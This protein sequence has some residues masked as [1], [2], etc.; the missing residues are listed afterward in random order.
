[1]PECKRNN[2]LLHFEEK[3]AKLF[4]EAMDKD[5]RQETLLKIRRTADFPALAGTVQ[6]INQFKASEESTVSE[7]TNIILKDYALTTKLLKVVNSVH[8]QQSGQVTTISRAV[9][10]LGIENIRNLALA[11]RLIDF[12]KNKDSGGELMDTL[13]RAFCAG[14]IA[15]K[16]AADLR[17]A[18]EEEAFICAMLHPLGKILVAYSMP[19]KATEIAK[20][21]RQHEISEDQ[22]SAMVLGISYEAI[23]TTM[24]T[25]WNLPQE[26]IRSMHSSP[27]DGF[28]GRATESEKLNML[29]T[30]GSGISDILASDADI[31]EM[32]VK[33]KSILS[34]CASPL[35]A[36]KMN[37]ETLVRKSF[38]ELGGMATSMGFDI[39]STRFNGKMEE[40]SAEGAPKT[41]ESDILAFRTDSLKS[42]ENLLSD[43]ETPENIFTRGIQDIN[44]SIL[45]TRNLNDV[46]RMAMETI[47]RAMTEANVRRVLFLVRNVKAPLLEV[48]LG[49]GPDIE[50]VK[51]WF[52]V[53]TG[54]QKDIFNIA[55]SQANDLIIRDIERGD[56]K[57]FVPD[58]YF[59]NV[60]S[61]GYLILLP[62]TVNKKNI[63]IYCIEGEKKGFDKISKGVL[64]YL[65]MLRDQTVFAIAHHTP[66]PG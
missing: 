27:P 61:P 13:V 58:W 31:C 29:A 21:A 30:I 23:G 64:G 65:R 47:F 53:R 10:L 11:L 62:I 51:L 63:G 43:D 25:E 41:S 12:F 8:Y 36:L 37:A 4:L 22:A 28:S 16:I 50:D 17:F 42:I 15:Q 32:E 45:Q 54:D 1:M 19:A 24:A 7:L 52:V 40:W 46:I 2:I 60:P 56:I 59:K 20:C 5:D 39:S 48:R 9:F 6:L 66:K 57:K 14:I 49:F 26:I 38:A 18:E 35:G 3:S 33:I 34:S 44:N 55:V